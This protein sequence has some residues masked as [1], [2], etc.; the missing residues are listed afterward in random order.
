MKVQFQK[1]D[2]L[3]Y[4]KLVIECEIPIELIQ[5]CSGKTLRPARGQ[6]SILAI[7][8]PFVLRCCNEYH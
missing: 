6:G 1:M 8:K 3:S 2:A 4:Y 5:I 7:I